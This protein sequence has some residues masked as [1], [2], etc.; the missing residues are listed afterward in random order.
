MTSLVGEGTTRSAGVSNFEPAHLERIIGETGVVPAV[1]QIEVHPFH[2]N[3]AAR[4]A[5]LGH[6]ALVEAW[7]PI[8]QGKVLTDPVVAKVA[9]EVGR[10]PSQVTL[11]W[12]IERG[13]VIFPKTTHPERMAE[14]F[15][16][17]DFSL[18]PDQVAA[19]SALDQGEAGRIGPNPETFDWVP[20]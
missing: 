15:A 4:T 8:A 12:H 6:G 16:L 2:G 1:N 3:E 18:T 9:E 14:N 13:D 10:T 11:R 20:A 19:I 17:F 5:T 7:S